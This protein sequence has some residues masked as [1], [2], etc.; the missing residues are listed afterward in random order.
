MR[1]QVWQSQSHSPQNMQCT[2]LE[3]GPVFLVSRFTNPC[4]HARSLVAT[5]TWNS[6]TP[7]SRLL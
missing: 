3:G 7:V 6:Q 1:Q 2:A 4:C 5:N